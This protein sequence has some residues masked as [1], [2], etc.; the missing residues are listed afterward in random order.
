[1]ADK[2]RYD[3]STTSYP[4]GVEQ[5][6]NEAYIQSII[7]AMKTAGIVGA[8]DSITGEQ[9]APIIAAV[10]MGIDTSD[11]TANASDIITGKTAYAKGNKITGSMPSLTND[12]MDIDVGND[13]LITAQVNNID[14]TPNFLEGRQM[15]F[16]EHQ[17]LTSYGGTFMPGTRP[18]TAA[19]GGSFV[20]NNVIIAGSSSLIPANIKR[21]VYI[22]GVQGTLDGIENLSYNDD[23]DMRITQSSSN[24]HTFAIR[25]S[26]TLPHT[27]KACFIYQRSQFS[28]SGTANLL[29]IYACCSG[30]AIIT[31]ASGTFLASIGTTCNW[32]GNNA[33]YSDLFSIN[34]NVNMGVPG[35]WIG[36][37]FM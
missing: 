21:S 15:I 3:T 25:H 17:L 11:A 35:N 33:A 36:T 16:K 28:L 37:I 29:A 1:M 27:P 26:T 32:Y 8:S 6:S 34:V 22:F 20:K 13:G 7:T 4:P 19:T 14:R 9:I 18:I 31:Q 10:R 2:E 23:I 24:V 5:A 12:N 30:R